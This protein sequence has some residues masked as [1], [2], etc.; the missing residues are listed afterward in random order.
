M[1]EKEEQFRLARYPKDHRLYSTV[2]DGIIPRGVTFKYVAFDGIDTNVDVSIDDFRG[3]VS[4]MEEH[5]LQTI[6]TEYDYPDEYLSIS[7][8][9]KLPRTQAQYDLQVKRIYEQ[10]TKDCDRDYKTFLMLKEKYELTL[11]K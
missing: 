11:T 7:G 4:K 10:H 2:E 8:Q 6:N 3:I 9:T 5:N 1:E